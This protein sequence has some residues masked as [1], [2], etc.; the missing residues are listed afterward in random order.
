MN[1]SV[2]ADQS[3]FDDQCLPRAKSFQASDKLRAQILPAG[4]AGSIVGGI[5]SGRWRWGDEPRSRKELDLAH[6]VFRHANVEIMR[7][8]IAN[9]DLSKNRFVLTIFGLAA[10]SRIFRVE[11]QFEIPKELS[12]RSAAWPREES[13]VALAASK[14]IPRR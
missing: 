1:R 13:A 5:G 3:G 8:R 2:V 9:L 12:F 14:Q 6:S 7:N 4:S 11:V 10:R